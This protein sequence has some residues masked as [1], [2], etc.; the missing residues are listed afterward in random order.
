MQVF[1][2]HCRALLCNKVL[3][4]TCDWSVVFSSY[5][6]FIVILSQVTDHHD[7]IESGVK[8]T[9]LI[10]TILHKCT[11]GATSG[12][13]TAYPSRTPEFTPVF[14]GSC[15]SIFSFMCMFCRSLF[16]LF[17]LAIVLPVLPF[18]ASDY[19]FGIFKLFVHYMMNC[20]SLYGGTLIYDCWITNLNSTFLISFPLIR[21]KSNTKYV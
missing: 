4:V 7:I 15:F 14:M 13:R 11:T 1:L 3:F 18:T 5:C 16:V 12:V 10:L 20:R 6:R 21:L 19:P 8:P 9:L 2:S 17:L